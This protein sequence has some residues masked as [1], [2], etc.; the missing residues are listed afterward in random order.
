MRQ[1]PRIVL[2]SACAW[3]AH[4]VLAADAA[5]KNILLLAGNPSHGPG[6]HE[7]NAGVLLLKK[8][9][10]ESGLPVR[11]TAHLNAQWPSNEELAQ[12]DTL[13]FYCDGGGGHLLLSGDRLA[14]IEKEVKRGAGFVCLHYAVEFPADRGGPQA[15]DWMGG[16]FE[17]NWS[18]N[19]HWDA[20][21]KELPKHP[22]SNGVDPFGTRDEWYFHMRFANADK[23]RLIH[24][25]ADVP[26]P[27]SVAPN[28]SGHGGNPAARAAVAAKKP[29]TT[30]WAFERKDGGR[31][32]GFTGGH[33]HRGWGNDDQ[34][35]LV[36]NAIL[37]TAKAEVP[38]DGVVSKITPEDLEANL[39]P[40]GQR[41]APKPAAFQGKPV[42]QSK[43]VSL[44]PVDI[45]ADLKGAKELYL[46]V[47][48]AGDG[49][50]ADWADWIEPTLVKADGSKIKLTELKPKSVQVGFGQLGVN[51]RSDGTPPMRVKGKDVAFGFATHAPAVV[52][53]VLPPGV[54]AFEAKGGIDEGGT[55]QGIGGCT[56][57]FQV[58]TKNPGDQA[59]RPAAAPA[60]PG[61][62]YGCQCAMARMVTLQTPKDFESSL[63]ATEPMVVNPTNVEVE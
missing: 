52:G 1:L 20:N 63:V 29:Q 38:K 22:I 42:F 59:N 2:A 48:D 44:E 56:V 15:L 19:P 17:L 28:D 5:K 3:F 33:F 58:Y 43:V 36:L 47:T 30:A 25:L 32:F 16:F 40:K 12:A 50:V 49:F 13:L 11:A 14:Q 61:E 18:V 31:G 23:G 60:S 53:F 26:P 21:Y 24:V 39:D 51:V 10:D 57:V 35:K 6:E 8:C 55:S 27:N 37:W 7:H 45:K 46:V 41:P 62:H 4:P 9:L 54:V 34:R